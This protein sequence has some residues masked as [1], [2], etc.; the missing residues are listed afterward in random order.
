ML[1]E[2]V[3]GG[4]DGTAGGEDVVPDWSSRLSCKLFILRRSGTIGRHVV[5]FLLRMIVSL[6]LFGLWV[7]FQLSGRPIGDYRTDWLAGIWAFAF[8]VALV[9]Q[10][11]AMFIAKVIRRKATKTAA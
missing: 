11:L 5:A 1:P 9:F 4:L 8:L 3:H 2:S 10:I 7:S 6:A